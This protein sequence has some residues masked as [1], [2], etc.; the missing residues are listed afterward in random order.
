MD[1]YEGRRRSSG[2]TEREYSGRTAYPQRGQEYQEYGERAA[3][4]RQEYD[5]RAAC[6]RQE[7]EYTRHPEPSRRRTAESRASGGERRPPKGQ[8]SPAARRRKRRRR[9]RMGGFAKILILLVIALGVAFLAFRFMEKMMSSEEEPVN[10]TGQTVTV[11]IPEG[12]STRDIAEILKEN[13]LIKSVFLFRLSSKL[14]GFDGTYQQGTYEIDTGLTKTQMMELLQTGSVMNRKK[15]TVPEG[16]TVRQIAELAAAAEICTID[17]F[18]TECNTG[19]FDYAFLKDLPEDKAKDRPYRLEGY[20]FPST[21]FLADEMTAHD[22]ID[23]MLAGFDNMYQKYKSDIEAS[24]HTLDELVTIASMVEKEIVLDEERARAAGVIENRL[25][26]GMSL[27][28]DATVLYAVGRTGGELTQEDLQTDSPYN[29]RKITGLPLGPISNPG[30]P[31]FEA[32][33]KPESHNYLYYVLEAQGKSNHVYCETYDE[34]LDAR[35]AYKAS[36]Q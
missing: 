31:S 17:E 10:L 35:D 2:Y 11:T 14:D 19:T 27:G 4:S 22:L 5:E 16:Y 23:M 30:E 28:I 36:L 1:D 8:P 7:R 13:K 21:Y 12:A 32:A 3:Y 18:I 25:K 20:L 33:V 26:Q 9:R 15:I 24:G 34:F 6:S 29:T